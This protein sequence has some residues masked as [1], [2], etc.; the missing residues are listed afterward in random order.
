MR[1]PALAGQSRPGDAAK[2]AWPRASAVS[3]PEPVKVV[4]LSTGVG[5]R[6]V[7]DLLA[8]AETSMKEGRFAAALDRYDQ[9]ERVAPGSALVTLGRAHAELGSSYYTRAAAHLRQALEADPALLVG[10]YD[11]QGFLGEQRLKTVRDDL[12]AIAAQERNGAAPAFL[13]A[14]VAY[15]TGDARAAAG[16]LDEAEKRTGGAD[17]LFAA[18][19]RHWTLPDAVGATTKPAPAVESN[20]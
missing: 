11:L 4:S 16:Y 14:Y 19:R 9:A 5:G 17:P 12:A 13:L 6:G 8:S 18:I 2:P 3:R 7:A 15:N 20:K 10:Q 1:N